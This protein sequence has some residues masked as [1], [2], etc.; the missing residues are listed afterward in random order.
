[1]R[2]FLGVVM[3]LLLVV[4]VVGGSAGVAYAAPGFFKLSETDG[5]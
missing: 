1:M 3:S 4:G 2:R 5:F